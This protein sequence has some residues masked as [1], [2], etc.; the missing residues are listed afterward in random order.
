MEAIRKVVNLKCHLKIGER[1]DIWYN[2][3]RKFSKKNF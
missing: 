1:S 3:V 2:V